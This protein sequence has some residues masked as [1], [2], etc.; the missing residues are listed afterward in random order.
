ML[1][2]AFIELINPTNEAPEGHWLR[3]VV[4]KSPSSL[5]AVNNV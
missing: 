1:S 4:A 3:S 5:K 2:V